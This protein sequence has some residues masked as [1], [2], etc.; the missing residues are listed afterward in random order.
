MA[1]VVVVAATECELRSDTSV[2]L[3][4]RCSGGC[5]VMKCEL[6]L[7]CLSRYMRKFAHAF[8]TPCVK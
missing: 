5:W 2:W 1:V 7:F 6:N 8:I 3:A 4:P